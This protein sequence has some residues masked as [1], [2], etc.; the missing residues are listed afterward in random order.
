MLDAL[1]N[2]LWVSKKKET[3]V[4]ECSSLNII[5]DIWDS[6]VEE[7]LHS[8]IVGGSCISS[9][10]SV[11]CSISYN[12][13]LGSKHLL[14][15]SISLFLF[16]KNLESESHWESS[17][18]LL[19]VLILNMVEHILNRLLVSSSSHNKSHTI[20][21]S[22]TND[23]RVSIIIKHL[24]KLRE[25]IWVLGSHTNKSKPE[26]D[27]MLDG[28]VLSR[29]SIS[30]KEVVNE[31]LTPLVLVDETICKVSTSTWVWGAWLL[32]RPMEVWVKDLK[33]SLFVSWVNDTEWGSCVEPIPVSCLSYP[34]EVVFQE[35]VV[36]GVGVHH[37]VG[38]D[39]G[40]M[41][42][43]GLWTDNLLDSVDNRDVSVVVLLQELE[44]KSISDL[45]SKN[46]ADLTK[47]LPG[48]LITLLDVTLEL[49]FDM[50]DH[51]GRVTLILLIAYVESDLE[52][53]KVSVSVRLNQ[54]F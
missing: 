24:L 6:T 33:G 41:E 4:S 49:F 17:D 51:L 26:T 16:A 22:L 39:S 1:W 15:Q 28:L 19:V 44:M 53:V 14:N 45:T 52:S 9:T 31:I 13:V 11:H 50:L 8:I 34:L 2:C 35:G 27:T 40:S 12:R 43:W 20:C 38:P 7:F 29:V 47:S 10:N 25:D 48:I 23:G 46:G 18:D 36:G 21:C 54:F 5:I 32:W 30:I 37:G 42:D 3:Q